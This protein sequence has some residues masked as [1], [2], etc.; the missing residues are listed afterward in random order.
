M[1]SGQ[2]DTKTEFVLEVELESLTAEPDVWDDV[3][4][5]QLT[6]PGSADTKVMKEIEFHR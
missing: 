4:C 3:E 1:S 6:V 2:C 5:Q